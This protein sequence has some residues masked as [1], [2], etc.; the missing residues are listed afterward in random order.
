K[1]SLH[2]KSEALNKFIEM[3]GV[4]FLEREVREEVVNDMI[5]EI[6]KMKKNKKKEVSFSDLD[7]LCGIE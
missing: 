3:Y 1:Y 5:K 7:K 4:D 2:N 6:S